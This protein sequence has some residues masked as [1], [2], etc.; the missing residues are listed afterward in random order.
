MR[1]WLTNCAWQDADGA[2]HI[3]VPRMLKELDVPDTP[4]TREAMTE[5]AAKILTDMLKDRPAV[6][7]VTE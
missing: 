3:D 5:M 6:I 7:K 1:E 4:E 2:L